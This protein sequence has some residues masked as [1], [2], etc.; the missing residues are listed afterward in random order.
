MSI[1]VTV[2]PFEKPLVGFI[3]IFMNSYDSNNTFVQILRIEL[4]NHQRTRDK[5]T[6]PRDIYPL[7]AR[8]AQEHGPRTSRLCVMGQQMRDGRGRSGEGNCGVTRWRGGERC[9]G[10]REGVHDTAS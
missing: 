1:R 3:G 9:G 10:E 6:W 7:G 8:D 2:N 4:V 5:F